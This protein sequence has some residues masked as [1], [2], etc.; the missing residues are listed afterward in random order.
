[1][2]ELA[3]ELLNAIAGFP[4]K[5]KYEKAVRRY[6]RRTAINIGVRMALVWPAEPA[7]VPDYIQLA[8]PSEESA[9]KEAV[10]SRISGMVAKALND[11][12]W[13]QAL[14]VLRGSD[15]PR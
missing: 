15:L 9:L 1:M 12:H 2:G 6:P 11:S 7:T 5:T 4:E 3:T 13:H 10:Y 14:E 8:I